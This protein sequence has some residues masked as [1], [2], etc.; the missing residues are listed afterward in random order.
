M[1]AVAPRLCGYTGRLVIL[2]DEKSLTPDRLRR[3]LFQNEFS[4]LL[5]LIHVVTLGRS[6]WTDGPGQRDPSG[7]ENV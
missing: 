7:N 6:P 3:S 5:G 1:A 4:L 2:L